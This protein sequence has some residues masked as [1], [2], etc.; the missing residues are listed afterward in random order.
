MAKAADW[1]DM[2]RWL[3][4]A[5]HSPVSDAEAHLLAGA[6]FSAMDGLAVYQNAYFVRLIAVLSDTFP[7][8]ARALGEEAFAALSR[9]YLERYPPRGPNLN[10]LGDGFSDY[11]AESCPD[12][13]QG[14][15]HAVID[16]ARYEWSLDATFDGPGFEG[17][18]ERLDEELSELSEGS[19]LEVSFRKHPAL[20]LLRLAFPVDLY[21]DALRASKEGDP[22]P[23][24]PAPSPRYLAITR[25]DYRVRV[26]VLDADEYV[27]LGALSEGASVLEALSRL[28]DPTMVAPDEV[29]AWFMRWMRE[30]LFVSLQQ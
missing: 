7:C 26:L 10:S 25:R 21:V 2:Q 16:L 12:D 19:W 27:V 5:L 29:Q 28:S 8:L 3:F 14:A 4:N 6:N 20:S 9:E 18:P 15:M 30:G 23:R 17:Q 1:S 24:L 13:A 22:A 11:L